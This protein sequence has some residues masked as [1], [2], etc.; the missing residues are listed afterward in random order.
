MNCYPCRSDRERVHILGGW[1]W[2]Q[3]VCWYTVTAYKSHISFL[4][5]IWGLVSTTGQ[6]LN[7]SECR[8]RDDDIHMPWVWLLAPPMNGNVHWYRQYPSY[9]QA[10]DAVITVVDNSYARTVSFCGCCWENCVVSYF[11]SCAIANWR[12]QPLLRRIF[13]NSYIYIAIIH[14][15]RGRMG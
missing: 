10:V 8:S 11:L 9:S 5:T 4:F 7:A 15:H 3:E 2:R 6:G 12:Y 14:S 13:W 1:T